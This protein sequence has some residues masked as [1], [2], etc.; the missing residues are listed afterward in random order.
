MA[1]ETTSS[2]EILAD[3]VD[4]PVA[5]QGRRARRRHEWTA[6]LQ[7]APAIGY[8]VVF[9]VIPLLILIVYSFYTYSNYN[10]STPFTLQN[11][12][13]AL[14]SSIYLTYLAR[15]F[16]VAL[17]V[18]FI[19]ITIAYLFCYVIN[20]LFPLRKRLIYFFVLVSLFGG[21]L[22]RIY[23][24]RTLLGTTGAINAALV[25]LGIVQHPVAIFLNSRFAIILVMVNFY[26]PLGVLPIYASMQNISPRLLEASKDLGAGTFT[27]VRQVLLPLTMP[28]VLAG[29]TFTFIGTSAEWVTPL[30][31][32]GTT[33]QLLGNQISYEFGTT[34]D[35]PMAAALAIT[36]I[37][38][39]ILAIGVVALLLR[40]WTR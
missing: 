26:L 16:F 18:T 29:I 12:I 38:A 33:D 7:L 34:L 23:A 9:F 36:L 11:Y 3:A 40:R 35:W 25:W 6:W 1:N 28:G 37:A 13:D 2:V 8:F 15:T 10:F 14:T 31:V 4:Q 30:L 20:F 5:P 39:E 32:G 27:T 24:W 19:V 17:I 22:V 21:Y